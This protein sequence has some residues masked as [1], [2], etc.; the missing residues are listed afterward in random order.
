MND[1]KGESGSSYSKSA[2]KRDAF[3]NIWK[4]DLSLQLW[5]ISNKSLGE[6]TIGVEKLMGFNISQSKLSISPN[7]KLGFNNIGKRELRI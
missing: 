3:E 1:E 6:K 5:T 4:R 2:K 7:W